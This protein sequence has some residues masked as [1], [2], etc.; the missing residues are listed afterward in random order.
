MHSGT[1]LV[2]QDSG[3]NKF[4]LISTKGEIKITDGTTAGGGTPVFGA[5]TKDS[6]E[7]PVDFLDLLNSPIDD[8]KL[9]NNASIL[10]EVLS[11]NA[12]SKSVTLKATANILRPDGTVTTKVPRFKAE[13]FPKKGLVGG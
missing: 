10:Y 9:E 7:V 6:T 2:V 5:A 1:D 3:A 13:A 11:V 12:Q 4:T 8:N